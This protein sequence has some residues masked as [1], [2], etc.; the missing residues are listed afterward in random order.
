MNYARL[1]PLC[2]FAGPTAAAFAILCAWDATGLDLSMAQWF[3][4]AHGFP[5]RDHWLLTGVMHEGA[6]FLSWL[7]VLGLCLGVWWPV[8]P[9]TRL[10]FS[11]RLQ[12]ACTPLAAALVVS[13]L[14]GVSATSCPW[15][16]VDF[17]GVAHHL[18]H[19]RLLV[20]D[21]GSGHCF[22]AG[23]ASSGFAFVGGFLAFRRVDRQIALRWLGGS[24]FAGLLLGFAQQMRGAHFMSHTLWT[25]WICWAVALGVHGAWPQTVE[26][27][28]CEP[29]LDQPQPSSGSMGPESPS[30]NSPP[31]AHDHSAP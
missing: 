10:D 28:P 8:G 3:G 16:L 26:E 22:P 7:L 17:G 13:L 20:R 14:K 9:L 15:D 11:R 21:G 23:H 30:G 5:L 24:L 18:P 12:L 29:E 2:A 6:R 1:R 31:L 4:G 25:A 27:Q 19:W